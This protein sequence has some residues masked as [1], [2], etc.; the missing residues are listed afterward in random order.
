[1]AQYAS[2]LVA[3]L[4]KLREKRAE[5]QPSL[6]AIDKVRQEGTQ[7]SRHIMSPLPF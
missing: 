1:M 4:D 7:I 2:G 5:I 3:I 6:D